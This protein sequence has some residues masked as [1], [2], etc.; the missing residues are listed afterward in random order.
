MKRPF[1]W[2]KLIFI[3]FGAAAILAL[4]SFIVMELWN[5]I[6][7]EVLQAGRISFWQ[8]AGIFI[9]CKILFGFGKGGNGSWMRR[10][11]EHKLHQMTP[12][13]KEEFKKRMMCGGYSWRRTAPSGE[14][15]L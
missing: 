4:I 12:E 13:E 10:R 6:L 15:N 1:N 11:M 7:P 2:K 9:L 14:A 5:R 8:A 3:P